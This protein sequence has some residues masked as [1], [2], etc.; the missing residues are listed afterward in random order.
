[1]LLTIP[2]LI[3]DYNNHMNG[4]D[5]ADQLRASYPTHRRGVRNWLPL[6]YWLLDTIKVNSYLLWRLHYPAAS[7]KH[8]Q[9][10]LAQQLVT[11]GLHE[12][13]VQLMQEKVV[14]TPIRSISG[15]PPSEITPKPCA[16]QYQVDNPLHCLTYIYN[17]KKKVLF[18][19][20]TVCKKLSGF[21]CLHW[22]NT[23]CSSPSSTCIHQLACSFTIVQ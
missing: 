21:Q 6:F 1:M 23:F 14:S 22:K 9:L 7:H 17:Q 11:E 15:L 2:D 4:V 19:Y 3:D 18:R 8:F 20:C 12:H 16:G 5:I 10:N 13:H